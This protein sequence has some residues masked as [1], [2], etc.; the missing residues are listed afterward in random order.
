VKSPLQRHQIDRS[1]GVGCG[2]DLASVGSTEARNAQTDYSFGD[3][4]LSAQLTNDTPSLC[5]KRSLRLW[6]RSAPSKQVSRLQFAGDS[7]NSSL[8]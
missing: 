5:T 8:E 3:F 6:L 1:N 4:L 7:K 2:A